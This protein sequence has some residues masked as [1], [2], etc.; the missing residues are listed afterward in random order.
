MV[1]LFP[2]GSADVKAALLP[3][4]AW[5]GLT[6]Y[7]LA[8]LTFCTGVVNLTALFL[9][10]GTHHYASPPS[11]HSHTPRV[12][13]PD[14]DERL[15]ACLLAVVALAVLLLT[16][17]AAMPRRAVEWEKSVGGGTG[18]EGSGRGGWRKPERPAIS[19]PFSD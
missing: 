17:Y 5:L 11:G 8:M 6:A 9:T 16:L 13:D 4:H 7:A 15:I 19:N 12:M 2:R 18:V 10:R 1:Y 14:G 3:S